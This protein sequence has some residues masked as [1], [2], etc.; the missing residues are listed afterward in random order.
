MT[1]CDLMATSSSNDLALSCRQPT[2]RRE[3]GVGRLE[4]HVRTPSSIS[5]TLLR[6]C[7]EGYRRSCWVANASREEQAPRS[8][9][10]FVIGNR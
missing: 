2:E 5:A 8:A 3:G 10:N 6:T 7:G 9:W 1:W 4:R